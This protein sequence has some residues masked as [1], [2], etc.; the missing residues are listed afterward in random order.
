MDDV[1]LGFPSIIQ[2]LDYSLE[3]D[4][5]EGLDNRVNEGTFCAWDVK[6]QGEGAPRQRCGDDE[7]CVGLNDEIQR[8]VVLKGLNDFEHL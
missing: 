7:E 6:A 8:R 2:V 4:V 3:N 5:D 1:N